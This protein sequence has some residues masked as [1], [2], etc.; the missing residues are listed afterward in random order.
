MD[1]FGD[2]S[3]EEAVVHTPEPTHSDWRGLN[4][5]TPLSTTDAVTNDFSDLLF[6]GDNPDPVFDSSR[7]SDDLS[8]LF[9]DSFFEENSPL[10][11]DLDDFDFEANATPQLQNPDDDLFA[12][13]VADVFAEAPEEL[14]ND[15]EAL[16]S[17]S[18]ATEENEFLAFEDSS[19]ELENLEGE[20]L[21]LDSAA[22]T[23]SDMDFG[24]LMEISES[25]AD[26]HPYGASPAGAVPPAQE[27]SDEPV[28]DD[29]ATDWSWGELDESAADFDFDAPA[30]FNQGEEVGDSINVE[31]LQFDDFGVD[32]DTT[33]LSQPTERSLD[34]SI[35]DRST[36][37]IPAQETES[38]SD[39]A[40]ENFM[41]T[42]EL[43]G[44]DDWNW[45]EEREISLDQVADFNL[46]G[47]FTDTTTADPMS[48]SLGQWDS[49]AA[50]E[51]SS[52]ENAATEESFWDENQPEIA[53]DE[54]ELAG[55]DAEGEASALD[56]DFEET[57]SDAFNLEANNN[58]DR[59]DLF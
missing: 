29:Q 14:L 46:E 10:E 28:M 31:S 40:L 55:M 25:V 4:T 57:A 26:A 27:L 50:E 11:Q 35:F 36:H 49:S 1:L 43:S 47:D 41:S 33:A 59:D 6:E 2:E 21:W 18:F 34:A 48:E 8:N 5:E 7:E 52:F 51:L 42:D 20:E 32:A 30:D 24:D 45:D 23:E 44:A 39:L 53:S 13:P 9:G 58:G 37:D 12:E 22:P 56:F 15:T 38:F 17:E 16:I 19:Q 54:L 3:L